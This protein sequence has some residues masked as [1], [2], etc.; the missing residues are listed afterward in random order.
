MIC[1]VWQCFQ[2]NLEL[3]DSVLLLL[4]LHLVTYRHHQYDWWILDSDDEDFCKAMKC[5]T[6]FDPLCS[7]LQP[8]ANQDRSALQASL[9][10]SCRFN[11]LLFWA[12][13]VWSRLKK[14]KKI[15]VG[16]NNI[17]EP[18]RWFSHFFIWPLMGERGG[19]FGFS[20]KIAIFDQP[21]EGGSFAIQTFGQHFPKHD[22]L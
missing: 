16:Q 5:R 21:G 1:V 11:H 19:H 14:I 10:P 3:E 2:A 6:A 7:S 13:A 20:E 9:D 15:K 12:A 8:S 4:Y 17:R 18:S 22:L